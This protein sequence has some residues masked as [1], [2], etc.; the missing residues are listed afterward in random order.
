M[1]AKAL[2]P[3]RASPANARLE[4]GAKFP[5]PHFRRRRLPNAAPL[6]NP[7][8]SSHTSAKMENERGELVDRMYSPV[9]AHLDYSR[10]RTP[11]KDAAHLS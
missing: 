6:K 8:P 3:L 1:G 9:H 4:E 5:Q 2:V 7:H 10:I 11:T